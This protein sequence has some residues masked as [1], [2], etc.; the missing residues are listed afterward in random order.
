M[1][2]MQRTIFRM[3]KASGEDVEEL[4]VSCGRL[5]DDV[6]TRI[7][8]LICGKEGTGAEIEIGAWEYAVASNDGEM[9][10]RLG[11]IVTTQANRERL[12]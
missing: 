11:E 3:L 9:L 10:E 4:R 1:L 12:E 2:R 5:M 8:N 6:D 7:D